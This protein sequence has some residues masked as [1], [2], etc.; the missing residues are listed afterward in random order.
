HDDLGQVRT[1]NAC[2]RLDRWHGRQ[3]RFWQWLCGDVCRHGSWR[4]PRQPARVGSERIGHRQR[5]DRGHSGSDRF[6]KYLQHSCHQHVIR[7]PI[8]ESYTLDPVDQA[9]EAAWKAGIVVVAAAGNEG[10]YAPTGGFGTIVVPGNDPSVI[11][12]GATMTEGTAT[13]VDDQIA[14]YSSK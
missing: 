7:R 8:F 4:E 1:R 14:S 11:T 13:R 6:A 12:V 10:R 5:S 2:G 3:F 9:V